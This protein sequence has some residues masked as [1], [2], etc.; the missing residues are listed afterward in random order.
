MYIY[1]LQTDSH[2][3]PGRLVKWTTEY[4]YSHVGISLSKECDRIYSF[5][6]RS[7]YNV[8][9]GGFVTEHRNGRFFQR[10]P[11]TRCRIYALEVTG[12]QYAAIRGRLAQMQSNQKRYKYDFLGAALRHFGIPVSFPNRYV[13]SQFVAQLLEQAHVYSFGKPSYF[14]QPK[15]FEGMI[16]AKE[17]YKGVYLDYPG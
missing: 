4:P 12:E 11:K 6:R 15:D 5:G 2:T 1:I 7:L 13:C 17:I 3:L 9:R 16:G 10:F 14:V 8:L